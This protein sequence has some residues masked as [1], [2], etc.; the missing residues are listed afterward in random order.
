MVTIWSVK[1][2]KDLF[3]K[4][5]ALHDLVISIKVPFLHQI[6]SKNATCG[7]LKLKTMTR[8]TNLIGSRQQELRLLLLR[9]LPL[10]ILKMKPKD[11]DG[12][13]W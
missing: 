4:D 7:C 3:A 13:L 6:D 11:A 8:F 10:S 2:F 5:G 9:S 1:P 12:D